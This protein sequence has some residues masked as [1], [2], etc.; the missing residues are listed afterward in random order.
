MTSRDIR[1]KNDRNAD[2][3]K[4]NRKHRNQNTFSPSSSPS[5]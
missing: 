5:L 3:A 2:N 4:Q 1:V